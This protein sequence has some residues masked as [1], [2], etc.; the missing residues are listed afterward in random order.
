MVRWR[1]INAP[2]A[3]WQEFVTPSLASK[4]LRIRQGET[5]RLVGR[6]VA[7]EQSC[8]C[9]EPCRG[10]SATYH[11]EVVVPFRISRAGAGFAP[12]AADHVGAP[13][14]IEYAG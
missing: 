3:R 14:I 4:L 8:P 12:R 5:R 10:R 13:R 1:T 7:W 6:R 11:L 2:A 9:G